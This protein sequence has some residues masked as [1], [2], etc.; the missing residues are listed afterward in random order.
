MWHLL[1]GQEPWLCSLPA[2]KG[3]SE[4][5]PDSCLQWLSANVGSLGFGLCRIWCCEGCA[6]VLLSPCWGLDCPSPLGFFLAL[7]RT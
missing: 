7:S 6:G 4:L 1:A 5:F 3:P 2:T